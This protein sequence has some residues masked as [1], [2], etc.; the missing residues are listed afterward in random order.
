MELSGRV[1]LGSV[2]ST[3]PHPQKYK[4]KKKTMTTTKTTRSNKRV[5]C[6]NFQVCLSLC[7][8]PWRHKMDRH[9][10][11]TSFYCLSK[12][13]FHCIFLHLPNIQLLQ[14]VLNTWY[15]LIIEC[16]KKQ[17]LNNKFLNLRET[18]NLRAFYLFVSNGSC[19]I[20]QQSE[21]VELIQIGMAQLMHTVWTV[22]C[23]EDS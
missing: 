14:S 7:N 1:T 21:R 6:L 11:A 2:P 18:N 4:Q 17:I 13:I 22:L 5:D 10:P 19:S 20:C 3:H 9:R 15:E 12:W 8:L 23:S 16:R